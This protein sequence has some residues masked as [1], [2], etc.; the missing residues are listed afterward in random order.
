M[1]HNVLVYV[2]IMRSHFI[3]PSGHSKTVRCIKFYYC[4]V[5]YTN[6]IRR[7]QRMLYIYHSI[8]CHSIDFVILSFT[9]LHFF[10]CPH[11]LLLPHF[12]HVDQHYA[13][14]DFV[15]YNLSIQLSIVFT[16]SLC[17]LF[18]PHAPSAT[19]ICSKCGGQNNPYAK[20]CAS[21]GVVLEPPQRPELKE[22][23]LNVNID[24][25]VMLNSDFWSLRKFL[26]ITFYWH[27][28]T[29]KLLCCGILEWVFCGILACPILFSRIL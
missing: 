14:R 27:I 7:I 11:F 26:H 19:L 4:V 9:F 20:F 6:V 15:S 8:Y 25:T 23:G 22:A 21:C 17:V 1:C 29:I 24:P 3:M 13:V 2:V 16:T 28:F 10:L 18:Q 5:E 12:T